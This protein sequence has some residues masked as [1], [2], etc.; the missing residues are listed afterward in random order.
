MTHPQKDIGGVELV[1][2]GQVVSAS[3][4]LPVDASVSATVDFGTKIDSATMPAG[5]VGNLGW[6][7]A[8]W[9]LL[10]TTGIAVDGS[11]HTQPISAAALPLPSGA[12]TAAKQPALGT[13]GTPSGDVISVQGHAGMTALVVDGSGVTQPISASALPLPSGAATA[14]KQPALG[15][16][17]AASA[18]VITVQGVASMTP[19]AVTASEP[20]SVATNQISV[21]TTAG[22]TV[23][24]AAR[25]GRK[26][27]T[28]INHGTTDV[29][30]GP[31]GVSTTSGALLTG[32]KG[33]GI[34]FDGGAAVYGIV[35]SGTQ[36]VSYVECY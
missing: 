24:C 35:D 30:V 16:A 20:S 5:G 21:G 33:A 31:N 34:A 18:D 1:V 26:S 10:G 17:G 12:A 28:I 2:D 11:G 23:I 29:Y 13:A 22:G 32:Q 3:N 27:L 8:I 25:A 7:S 6:L 9:Y 4:K 14:A 36:T 19:L 15:T